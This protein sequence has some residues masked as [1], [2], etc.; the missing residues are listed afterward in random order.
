MVANCNGCQLF[1]QTER[2]LYPQL[3]ES[4]KESVG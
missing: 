3:G 1:V 4:A 2:Y